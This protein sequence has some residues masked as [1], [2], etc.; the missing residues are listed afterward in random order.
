MGDNSVLDDICYLDLT[1]L[2]WSRAWTFVRR[3]DH[4]AWI[5][6]EKLWVF[7]GLGQDMGRD[8]EVWWLDLK[9][10]PAFGIDTATDGR[11][12]YGRPLTGARSN[13][14]LRPTYTAGG[15]GLGV[16][17]QANQTSV[18]ANASLAI[19]PSH[20]S[21]ALGISSLSFL[22]SPEYP[23]QASGTHFYVYSSNALLDF[24]TPAS[25][26]RPTD[27]GLA[28][29][30]LPALRWQRLAEGAEI[31]N[32]GYRWH[33]CAINQ[34]GTKAWLLGCATDLQSGHDGSFEEYLCDVLTIDLGWFGLL[35]NSTSSQLGPRSNGATATGGHLDSSSSGLGMDL[36]RMF[37]RSFEQGSGSDFI[38]TADP[39]EL[40]SSGE[41]DDVRTSPL[42]EPSSRRATSPPIHVHLLILQAR[43]AHFGRLFNSGMIE[44]Q[45]GRMHIPEPYSVVRAFLF[46]LYTDSIARPPPHGKELDSSEVAGLL[47]MANLYDLP[48]L[49]VLCVH[50]LGR[51]LEVE[52]A[53]LVWERAGTAN[54]DWLRRRAAGFCLKHWGRVVRT[55]AFRKLGRQAL[56]ELCE[57]IDT[58]GRVIGGGELE[59]VHGLGGDRI[60][61]GAWGRA[62]P[63]ICATSAA[64]A[65]RAADGP[66]EGEG[67]DSEMEV[68]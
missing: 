39:D 63:S 7:G 31:F 2:T 48:G 23:P 6:G 20:T 57:E 25:T 33:Y 45:T 62:S 37:D 19:R 55:E 65:A 47:V 36:A 11:L 21:P 8:G 17:Y 43:W 38:V 1:T 49:R 34:D 66:E 60:G 64:A 5:W 4:A 68:S 28:A 27:C 42:A 10:D 15:T 67:E 58:E 53:A 18:H 35:G 59:A 46:Y 30:D 52:H 22:S 14:Q 26:I 32:P 24:V 13:S 51:E 29:L 61:L 12:E 41:E 3:F 50:R 44:S 9:A 56:G 54:E 16:L 40:I